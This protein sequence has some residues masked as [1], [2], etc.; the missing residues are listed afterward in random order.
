MTSPAEFLTIQNGNFLSD[1]DDD[2]DGDDEDN[3][4]DNNY[5]DNSKHIDNQG[6]F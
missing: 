5:N 3:N 2:C 6:F 1:D 4:V